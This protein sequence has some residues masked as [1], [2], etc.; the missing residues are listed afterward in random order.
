MPEAANFKYIY[1]G[2]R[3]EPNIYLLGSGKFNVV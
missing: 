2:Y 1:V 3:L